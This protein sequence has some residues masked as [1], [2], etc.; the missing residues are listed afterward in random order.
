MLASRTV[1]T[2]RHWAGC[3]ALLMAAAGATLPGPATTPLLAATP[4]HQLSLNVN[5]A[6]SHELSAIS[7][8]AMV[9]EANAIWWDSN[10]SLIWWTGEV[11]E[12]VAPEA[13]AHD[14]LRVLVLARH[15][16][17]AGHAAT[18]TVG[19]LVNREGAKS[20]AIASLTA[21]RRVV[22][23]SLR[24]RILD[25]PRE[26][27]HRLGVVLGRAVAH[28]I[29]HYLLRTGTHAREGLMR[30]SID[31]QEFADVRSRAFR[32]DGAAQAHLAKLAAAAPQPA[33]SYASR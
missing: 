13:D 31:V 32:L 18:L 19:E 6:S 14:A 33:F 16:P 26:Y 27:D 30:A 1:A 8:G 25:S 11:N 2:A 5:L 23:E 24:F 28:E 22:D 9:A 21:A 17:G 29:G 3:I 7:T 15:A 12:P 10:L 20:I 4:V